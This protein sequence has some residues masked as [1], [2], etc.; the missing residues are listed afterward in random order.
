L[1]QAAIAWSRAAV[2]SV[3]PSATAPVIR[4]DKITRGKH[5][6]L[7]AR[8]NFRRLRPSGRLR[9]EQWG[10]E[11]GDQKKWNRFF[12]WFDF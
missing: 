4:D 2:Q 12:S 5:R 3:W 1:A 6:R 8:Q 7:D 10:G 9:A 11:Q